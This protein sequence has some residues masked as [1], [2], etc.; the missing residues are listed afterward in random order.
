MA[1]E[2][3]IQCKDI[4][5]EELLMRMAGSK[6][7]GDIGWQLLNWWP[8]KVVIRKLE[9]LE[10]RG[11]IKRNATWSNAWLTGVGK[12]MAEQVVE[13]RVARCRMSAEYSGSARKMKTVEMRLLSLRTKSKSIL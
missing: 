12:E 7:Q 4:D 11:L 1:M 8:M 9:G 13:T 5:T 6:Y 3:R 2:K 10:R